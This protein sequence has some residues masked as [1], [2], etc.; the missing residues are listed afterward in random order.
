MKLALQWALL[1]ILQ[2]NAP[3]A[4]PWKPKVLPLLPR[5]Q[6]ALVWRLLL[7]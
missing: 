2:S 7:S 1:A 4:G 3:A 6:L 5:L